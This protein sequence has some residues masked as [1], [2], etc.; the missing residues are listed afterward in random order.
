MDDDSEQLARFEEM[1]EETVRLHVQTFGFA[2]TNHRLAIKWLAQKDQESK[3]RNEAAHLEQNLTA[4]TAKNGAIVA[5]IAATITIPLAIIAIV[6]STLAW[7]Y[8]HR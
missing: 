5:A 2:I 7:I 3:R 6:I 1:G 8:P 4:R